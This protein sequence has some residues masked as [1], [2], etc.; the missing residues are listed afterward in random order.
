MAMHQVSGA[1]AAVG[2]GA[3]ATFM[4]WPRSGA[5]TRASSGRVPQENAGRPDAEDHRQMVSETLGLVAGSLRVHSSGRR[6]RVADVLGF[7]GHA[8]PGCDHLIRGVAAPLSVATGQ[9]AVCRTASRRRRTDPG[10]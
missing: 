7:G 9:V 6:Y 1:G 2:A 8:K 10:R 3:V 4:G 5:R